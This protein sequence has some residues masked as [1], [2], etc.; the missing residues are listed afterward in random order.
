MAHRLGTLVLLAEDQGSVHSTHTVSHN[1]LKLRLHESDPRHVHS[2]HI[3]MHAEEILL[4]GP[5]NKNPFKK[6]HL[7]ILKKC[8]GSHSG[9]L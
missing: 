7:L 6:E 3:C 5:Q 2:A 1:H 8:L 4:H 9:F